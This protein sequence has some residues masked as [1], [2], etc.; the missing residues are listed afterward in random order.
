MLSAAYERS[1]GAETSV[2]GVTSPNEMSF[3]GGVTFI[4]QSERRAQ[5][6]EFNYYG[7]TVFFKKLICI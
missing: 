7:Y 2:S 3:E 5:H 6:M 4:E 1:D